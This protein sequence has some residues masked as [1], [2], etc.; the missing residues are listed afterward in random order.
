MYPKMHVRAEITTKLHIT[1]A[2]LNNDVDLGLS[3][4]PIDHPNIVQKQI[5]SGRLVCVIARQHPLAQLSEIGLGQ[6]RA[7]PLIS[8]TR[9]IDHGQI[10]D[11]AFL[12]AGMERDIAIEVMSSQAACWF[13]RQGDGVALI[14]EF[15]VA[16]NSFPDL[17]RITLKPE[18]RFDVNVVS[19]QFRPLS[20]V[21][22]EFVVMLR[23]IA[24]LGGD[25]RRIDPMNMKC[26]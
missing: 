4:A 3:I 20:A 23:E 7:Y 10:I 22:N 16:G 8:Y 11:D 9:D 6:L 26:R 1:N 13:V 25:S 24:E 5:A 18:I 14:D 12:N 17:H 2:L 21:L 19:N 15:A